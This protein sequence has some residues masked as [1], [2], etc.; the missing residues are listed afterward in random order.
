[1]PSIAASNWYNLRFI[2]PNNNN[3][4]FKKSKIKYWKNVDIYIGGSEHTNG[5]LI[6]SRFLH[7]FLYDIKI[8]NFKE[9]FKKFLNQGIILYNS[10]SIYKLKNKNIFISYEIIKNYNRNYLLKIYI[11]RKY[12]I[13]NNYLNIKLFK[14]KNLNQN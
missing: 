8:I 5:H 11:N 6:Y 7:K 2:D 10:Y 1:M 14:K 13:N 9:P 12:V 3:F 4:L